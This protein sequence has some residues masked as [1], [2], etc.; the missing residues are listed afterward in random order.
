MIT[1][2]NIQVHKER[3]LFNIG[4]SVVWTYKAHDMGCSHYYVIA[5]AY[6]AKEFHLYSAKIKEGKIAKKKEI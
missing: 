4:K 2:T 5:I 6:P 3:S 1:V